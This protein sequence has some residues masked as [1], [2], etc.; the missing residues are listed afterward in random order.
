MKSR[1]FEI[2]LTM[3]YVLVISSLGA[4]L[5]FI[6]VNELCEYKAVKYAHKLKSL[7]YETMIWKNACFVKYHNNWEVCKNIKHNNLISHDSYKTNRGA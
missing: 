5:I 1:L 7:G 2:L 6:S 4:Y 3:L